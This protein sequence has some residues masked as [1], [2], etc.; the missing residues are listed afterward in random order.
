MFNDPILH[1]HIFG[2]DFSNPIGMAAG[3]DKNVEVVNSLLNLGFGFVEAGTITPKPQF[4][5]DKPR[6]F[7]LK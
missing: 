4:G 2:F 5:N 3:F 6:I 7:R 1:Q